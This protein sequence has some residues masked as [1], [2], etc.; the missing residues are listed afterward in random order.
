M[1]DRDRAEVLA[2][3]LRERLRGVERVVEE[4]SVPQAEAVSYAQLKDLIWQ[5]AAPL[6]LSML[7]FSAADRAHRE[8]DV[9]TDLLATRALFA[10]IGQ[11]TGALLERFL[12]AAGDLQP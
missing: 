2:E 9:D 1:D 11:D 4:W 12:V 3:I 7:G 5:L 6:G 8:G 10:R